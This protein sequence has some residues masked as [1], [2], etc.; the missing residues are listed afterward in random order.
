[1]PE[2]GDI[3]ISNIYRTNVAAQNSLLGL[4]TEELLHFKQIHQRGLL[5]RAGH[6]IEYLIDGLEDQIA[7]HMELNGFRPTF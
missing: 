4:R 6:E 1:M 5:G 2:S 7:P 3:L